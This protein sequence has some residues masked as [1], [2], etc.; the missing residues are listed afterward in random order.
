MLDVGTMA[1][2]FEATLD[3]GTSFRLSDLRDKKNVVLYFYPAAFSGGCTRQACQFR[4][5]YEAISAY[6]AV[7]IGVS[8]DTASKHTASRQRYNLGFPMI[9]ATDDLLRTYDV[10][11]FLRIRARVTYV[12]DK[13][14][15]VRSAFRHDIAIGR[16]VD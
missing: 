3:D 5:S 2:D 16:H 14:G 9:R 10:K 13:A 6:D 1:P 15:M 8:K 4:D 7:I 12:I 11:T